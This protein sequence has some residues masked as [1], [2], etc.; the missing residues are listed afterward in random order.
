MAAQ[1][2]A[3]LEDLAA[4]VVG[5]RPPGHPLEEHLEGDHALGAAALTLGA[6]V[7]T[8]QLR[9]HIERY[10]NV[11]DQANPDVVFFGGETSILKQVEFRFP[12]EIVLGVFFV[13]IALIMVGPGQEMGRAFNRVP[14]RGRAYALNLLGSLAGI[15]LFATGATFELPP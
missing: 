5:D 3:A 7:M 13:L 9:E 10:V 6:G 12:L 15:L 14:H 8:V 1:E 2:V 11:A 4:E